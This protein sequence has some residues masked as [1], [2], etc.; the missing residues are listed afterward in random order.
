MVCIQSMLV[1]GS[2]CPF[3]SD[4]LCS[5]QLPYWVS[6]LY[7]LL[8]P[9]CMSLDFLLAKNWL[10]IEPRPAGHL[11][12]SKQSTLPASL[13]SST[14]LP[15]RSALTYWEEDVYIPSRMDLRKSRY[16]GS[17]TTEQVEDVKTI[18]LFLPLCLTIWILG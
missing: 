4:A 2:Q 17:F 5:S 15:S 7:S 1:L 3:I 16:G 14:K 13:L 12:P 8:P 11:S 18:L 10:I 9:L 6:Q